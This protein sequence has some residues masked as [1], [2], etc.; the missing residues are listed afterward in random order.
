MNKGTILC[1]NIVF[2]LFCLDSMHCYYLSRRFTF[3]HVLCILEICNTK[4]T[5][6]LFTLA[7]MHFRSHEHQLGGYYSVKKYAHEM[8]GKAA[9]HINNNIKGV[10]RF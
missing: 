2:G 9:S 6:G 1:L 4:S 7:V 8:Q 5:I 3:E 10:V